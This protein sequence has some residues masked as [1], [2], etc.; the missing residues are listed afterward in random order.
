MRL[1]EFGPAPIVGRTL[2]ILCAYRGGV[3]QRMPWRCP[4]RG[5]WLGRLFAAGVDLITLHRIRSFVAQMRDHY[6]NPRS[7]AAQVGIAQ[8]ALTT[9][10]ATS[11]HSVVD[12]LWVAGP[13]EPLPFDCKP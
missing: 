4:G 7:F 1:G 5:N 8:A 13:L 2:V 12:A 3:G 10:E 9:S 11:V 6:A